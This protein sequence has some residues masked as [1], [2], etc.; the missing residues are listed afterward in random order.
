[1]ALIGFTRTPIGIAESQYA[2]AVFGDYV[3]VYDMQRGVEN[4]V[5][6]PICYENRLANAG[7]RP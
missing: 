6:V 1:M 5:T 7:D 4:G 3:S 2:L